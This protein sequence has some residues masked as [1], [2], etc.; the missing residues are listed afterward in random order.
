MLDVLL[1]LNGKWH[2]FVT[3]V[4]DEQLHQMLAGES[5]DQTLAM[6]VDA[7]NKIVCDRGIKG[8]RGRDAMM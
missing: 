6:L 1:S 4:E 8:P 5:L 7:A 3:L 2:R